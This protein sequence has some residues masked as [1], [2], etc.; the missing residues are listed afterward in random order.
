RRRRR[1][2]GRRAPPRAPRPDAPRGGPQ[3]PGGGDR[4]AAAL[5]DRGGVSGRRIA[6]RMTEDRGGGPSAAGR[7]V[8]PYLATRAG[9]PARPTPAAAPRR[10]AR[11]RPPARSP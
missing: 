11:R 1:A 7:T 3:G 4:A 2:V 8:R 6:S 5:P 9:A 10:T